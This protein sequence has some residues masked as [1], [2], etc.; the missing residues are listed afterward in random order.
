MT[1]VYKVSNGITGFF[2][3]D[4]IRAENMDEAKKIFDAKYPHGDK[5]LAFQ[6][7]DHPVQAV[8]FSDS[9]YPAFF[10]GSKTD[11]RNGGNLYIRQWQLDAK[12]EKI[13]TI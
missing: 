13:E 6:S 5:A 12:I 7:V 1:R 9:T 4:Y 10:K 11:A 3:T 2:Q 8:Y